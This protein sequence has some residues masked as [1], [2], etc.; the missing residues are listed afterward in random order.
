MPAG[1]IKL[2]SGDLRTLAGQYDAA[3]LDIT[4]QI[5]NL[6]TILAGLQA[7]FAGTSAEALWGAWGTIHKDLNTI[8]TLLTESAKSARDVA[9]AFESAEHAVSRFF[10]GLRGG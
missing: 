5:A 2:S 4:G 9:G 8:P 1:T 3:A 10:K 6:D 7:D